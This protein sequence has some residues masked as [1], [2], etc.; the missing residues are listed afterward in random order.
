MI[1]AHRNILR[2]KY[3]SDQL[4]RENQNLYCMLI[5]PENLAM[6]QNIVQPDIPQMKTKYSA[7]SMRFACKI[8]KA[9]SH[10]I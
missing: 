8:K 1:A 10:S 7:K 9:Y 5:F 3:V 2:M 4:C 6:Y